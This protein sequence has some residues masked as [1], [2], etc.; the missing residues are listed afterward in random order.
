MFIAINKLIHQ[1]KRRQAVFAFLFTLL[2]GSWAWFYISS[3]DRQTSSKVTSHLDHYANGLASSQD[4]YKNQAVKN[5]IRKHVSELQKPWLDYL[6]NSP[7]I[8]QGAIEI[9]WEIDAQGNIDSAGIIHSEFAEKAFERNLLT[10]VQKIK[11]PHPPL[12]QRVYVTHKFRFEK[13]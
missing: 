2:L 13:E 8:T 4:A 1:R 12:E 5:T 9:D 6:S 3:G 7:S 10:A 11:F